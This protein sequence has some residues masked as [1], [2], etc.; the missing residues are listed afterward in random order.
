M[1]SRLSRSSLLGHAVGR[2]EQ[3]A[4]YSGDAYD[5]DANIAPWPTPVLERVSRHKLR[6][7]ERESFLRNLLERSIEHTMTVNKVIDTI[8]SN[9]F[10]DYH[11]LMASPPSD[12]SSKFDSETL[13]SEQAK[14]LK[15]FKVLIIALGNAREQQA[16]LEWNL[17]QLLK[18]ELSVDDDTRIRGESELVKAVEELAE[19]LGAMSTGNSDVAL[20]HNSV[21]A[22]DNPLFEPA[23]ALSTGE[24]SKN[25][26]EGDLAIL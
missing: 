5:Y 19:T 15:L 8:L 14:T 18:E 11:E 20:V 10:P 16:E 4:N 24:E 3:L 9:F 26:D 12:G 2:N 21:T 22:S 13:M 17:N 25:R 6:A 7:S 1:R 23:E